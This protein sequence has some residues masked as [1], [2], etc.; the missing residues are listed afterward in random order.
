MEILLKGTREQI[1]VSL[2]VMTRTLLLLT[3]ILLISK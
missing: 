1:F 2:S 3:F